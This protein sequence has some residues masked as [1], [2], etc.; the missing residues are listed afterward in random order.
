VSLEHQTLRGFLYSACLLFIVLCAVYTVP[1][2]NVSCVLNHNFARYSAYAVQS[3]QSHSTLP[4][5]SALPPHNAWYLEVSFTRV[6]TL[7]AQGARSHT[8]DK[9]SHTV[10][11][12]LNAHKKCT[13][14]YAKKVKTKIPFR[15]SWN[16]TKLYYDCPTCLSL[17]SWMLIHAR[18]KQ[19]VTHLCKTEKD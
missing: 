4:P 17:H 7:L 16:G 19:R 8:P 2:C 15:S 9:V 10:T 6:P 13:H 1:F 12:F 18:C 14:T 3:I 5:D 11:T